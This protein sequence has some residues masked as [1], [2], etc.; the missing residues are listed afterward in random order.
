MHRNFLSSS[1]RRPT[2]L[3]LLAAGLLAALVLGVASSAAARGGAGAVPEAAGSSFNSSFN[4]SS[5]GWKAESGKWSLS[6]SGFFRSAAPLLQWSSA[7]RAGTF[8]NFVYVVR[9]KKGAGCPTCLIGIIVRGIPSPLGG[10]QEWHTGYYLQY[11]NAG[12]VEVD[13]IENGVP[14]TVVP[15][16]SGGINAYGW[17]TLK[18]VVYGANLLYYVNGNMVTSYTDGS[19]LPAGQVGFG[20]MGGGG[21]ERLLVDWA[22]LQ[23]IQY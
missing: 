9:M 15:P 23:V 2:S 22:R 16:T 12:D 10:F 20:H 4:G 8:N 11:N 21:T 6:G 3:A 1:R 19:P 14:T 7:S 17:N 5:A 13:R 18:V